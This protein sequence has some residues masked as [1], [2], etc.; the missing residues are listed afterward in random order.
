MERRYAFVANKG[1]LE[2]YAQGG[3]DGRSNNG[4]WKLIGTGS[5]QDLGVALQ[6]Q[7]LVEPVFSFVDPGEVDPEFGEP[8]EAT[9]RTFMQGFIGK[10]R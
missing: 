3:D 2:L 7:S 8:D 9:F 1:E 6:R 4:D 10:L 5:P